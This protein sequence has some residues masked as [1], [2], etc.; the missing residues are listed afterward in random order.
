MNPIRFLGLR[1][2]RLRS[3]LNPRHTL[4]LPLPFKVLFNLSI[5]LVLLPLRSRL[6]FLQQLCIHPPLFGSQDR[7]RILRLHLRRLQS[8]DSPR[9]MD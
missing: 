8:P 1:N 3:F 6:L 5:Q 4:V 2:R 9:G 7:L